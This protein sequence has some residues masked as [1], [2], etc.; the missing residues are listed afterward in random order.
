[1]DQARRHKS[2]HGLMPVT[3]GPWNRQI[4]RRK[5]EWW[6]QAAG[7]GGEAS[8]CLMGKEFVWNEEKH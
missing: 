3:G 7:G 5:T 1:M 6:G 2:T 4:Q 8:E